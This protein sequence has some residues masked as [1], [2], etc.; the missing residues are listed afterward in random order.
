MGYF[1]T[2]KAMSCD[3]YP[4]GDFKEGLWQTKDIE[5]M[6]EVWNGDDDAL[7]REDN[8][9]GLDTFMNKHSD[10]P[11]ELLEFVGETSDGKY[12]K[13]IPVFTGSRRGWVLMT[14]RA[15]QDYMGIA[16]TANF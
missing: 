4:D 3:T 10:G 9:M 6:D 16:Q 8:P 12:Q 13:A 2:V 5:D 1:V 7:G 11:A 15:W 14:K